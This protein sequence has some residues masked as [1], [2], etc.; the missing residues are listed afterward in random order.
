MAAIEIG[1]PY[2][3]STTPPA[4]SRARIFVCGHRPGAPRG[5]VPPSYR[6]RL[7][8][9]RVPATGCT[10]GSGDLRRSRRAG[11][12]SRRAARGSTCRRHRSDAGVAGF[13]VPHRARPAPCRHER[14][15]RSS[16]RLHQRFSRNPAAPQA[17][18]SAITSSRRACRISCGRAC[19]TPSC[20]GSRI[21]ASCGGP[22]VLEREVRRMLQDEKARTLVEEFGGQWLQVRALESV[23]PDKERFPGFDD[24][25]RF[26]MRRETEL[27]F[28]SIIREDR[29]IFDFLERAVHVPQRAA[30]AALRHR[31][32]DRPRV[33]A[34]RGR[35]PSRGGVLTQAS[36]L[37]VSS[38]A[39][40]TSPVLRGKWI[41]ENLLGAPP[42]DPP[43]GVPEPDEAKARHDGV[44]C[45][46]S[47]KRTARTRRAPPVTAG[48]IRW[49]SGSRT[50]TAI[51]A[52]R[53]I[54]GGIPIDASGELPDGR[55]FDGPVELREHPRA[56]ARR[57]RA[58][59]DVEAA[60]LRAR[61]RPDAGGP[62][63]RPHDCARPARARLPLLGARA[64]NRARARPS[65]C[66]EVAQS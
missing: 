47:S 29:S 16:V 28:A 34:R 27:F 11:P 51:G 9:P 19:P 41:L 32:R 8:P 40:R 59:A 52:W 22:A 58:G 33:P 63:D 57:L 20:G 60:H 3:Q 53:T 5:R 23:A 64:R 10:G 65:R 56:R 46:S 37:T 50:S 61:P 48:W 25:L 14:C 7:R 13:P 15:R 24:Y 2:A 39:T 18:R 1:G 26:S 44:A 6:H 54:D 55:T 43:P 49:A 21:A 30:G 36:V 66:D 17:C 45:G 42:P 38:Y 62:A 4:E 35:R 31:G 12:T